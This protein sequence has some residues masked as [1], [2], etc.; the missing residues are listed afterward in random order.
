MLVSQQ[1]ACL[2]SF[3]KMLVCLEISVWETSRK[4]E[5]GDDKIQKNLKTY[6]SKGI[7][8]QVEL[9]N[10]QV[11]TNALTISRIR[12]PNL[13]RWNWLGTRNTVS[14][15]WPGR[16]SRS[17]SGSFDPEVRA[18]TAWCPETSSWRSTERMSGWLRGT[19]SSNEFETAP[20]KYVWLKF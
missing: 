12:I 2:P 20:K 18:S 3:A 6:K 7:R 5:D 19:T 17:S 8:P 10:T 15:S 13:E 14:G 1:L 16:R 9:P 4:K 11:M